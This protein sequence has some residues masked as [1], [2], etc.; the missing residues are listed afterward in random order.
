MALFEAFFAFFG[1]Q[2]A[3]YVKFFER[4]SRRLS[5]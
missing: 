2:N 5:G 1:T 4:E 3:F